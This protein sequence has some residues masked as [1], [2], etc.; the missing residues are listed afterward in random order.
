MAI[1]KQV[2]INDEFITLGQF[3]KITDL[4]NS[5]GEAKVFLATNE[6]IIN[7]EVDNRRGRKLYKG[8]LIE[9][10]HKTYEIC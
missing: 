10:S 6:V 9:V 1:T 4:I 2:K 8:D 5:G 3:L 7:N